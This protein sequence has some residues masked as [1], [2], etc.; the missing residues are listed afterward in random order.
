MFVNNI[1]FGKI[2]N[3]HIIKRKLHLLLQ[4]HLRQKETRVSTKLFLP[5]I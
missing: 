4:L 1:V 2:S 5:Y 3:E